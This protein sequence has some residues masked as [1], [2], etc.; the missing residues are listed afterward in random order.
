MRKL[1]SYLHKNERGFTLV[2]LLIVVIILAV[3][4]GIAVPS[5]MALRNRARES[6]T[7]SEMRNIATAIEMYNADKNYYPKTSSIDELKVA[8]E[9]DPGYMAVVPTKDMWGVGYGYESTDGKTYTLTS[10]GVDGETGGDD[11][12]V[13]TDGVMTSQGGYPNR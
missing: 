12:I 3:L 13:F 7:E 11:N 4:S 8:L 9:G 6:G 10:C 2:E 1:Y 5:Y